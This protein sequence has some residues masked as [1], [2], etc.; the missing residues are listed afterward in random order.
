M[1]NDVTRY[2]LTLLLVMALAVGANGCAIGGAGVT[3]NN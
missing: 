1:R 3:S 2:A